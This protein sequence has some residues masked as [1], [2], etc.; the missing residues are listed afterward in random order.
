MSVL[1][2][3]TVFDMMSFPTHTTTHSV[4]V[5]LQSF[6]DDI[7]LQT[8]T[9]IYSNN[10]SYGDFMFVAG[11][12][13]HGMTSHDIGACPLTNENTCSWAELHAARSRDPAVPVHTSRML[14]VPISNCTSIRQRESSSVLPFSVLVGPD[15][16]SLVLSSPVWF[17]P[18]KRRCPLLHED[19]CLDCFHSV[20]PL[21]GGLTRFGPVQLSGPAAAH[22]GP[23]GSGS[24]SPHRSC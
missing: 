16:S 22:W 8:I 7:S 14:L 10:P 15:L 21:G 23:T 4:A 5:F 9:L 2:A 3:W 12:T 17:G 18:L 13:T 20:A 6:I 11:D 1:D 24:D 19:G